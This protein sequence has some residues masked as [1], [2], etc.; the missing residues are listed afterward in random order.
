MPINIV[1][2]LEDDKARGGFLKLN[3]LTKDAIKS[4]LILLLTTEK[5]ERY[6]L[7]EYG[8]NLKNFIFEPS[9]QATQF[10]IEEDIKKAVKRFIPKLTIKTV[11]FLQNVVN[12]INSIIVTVTFI[13]GDGFF[14]EQDKVQ[15]TFT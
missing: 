10:A 3:T 7:P 13:Y 11:E 1:F 5:G 4:D 14:E 2:P 8:T 12:G 9:D 15:I 6:Y